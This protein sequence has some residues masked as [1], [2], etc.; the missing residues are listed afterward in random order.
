VVSEDGGH[1]DS[2]DTS[3]NSTEYSDGSSAT[4]SH[5]NNGDGSFTERS[6]R[7]RSD[8]TMVI[9][10]SQGTY[11]R[12]GGTLHSYTR[13]KIDKNGNLI[14]SVAGTYDSQG[15]PTDDVIDP[16]ADP[17]NPATGLGG[18]KAWGD[19]MAIVKQPVHGDA[20]TGTSG[21]SSTS[22]LGTAVVTN[23]DNHDGSSG[24]GGGGG[25]IGSNQPDGDPEPDIPGGSTTAAAVG[26][27]AESLGSESLG[28]KRR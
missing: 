4:E 28:S 23:P 21:R 3:W 24:R 5:R 17:T 20:E 2:T 26:M 9:T 11:G 18:K 8:G 25:G 1:E 15:A 22:R 27:N 16:D 7:T 12:G 14:G 19:P 10:V 6:T 13:R